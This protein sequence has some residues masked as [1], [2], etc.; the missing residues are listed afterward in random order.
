MNRAD[1]HASESR[2]LKHPLFIWRQQ[3]GSRSAPTVMW[4]QSRAHLGH[5]QDDAKVVL[6]HERLAVLA[7]VPFRL[8]SELFD[9]SLQIE[10]Q[11][12]SSHRTSVWSCVLSLGV[13]GI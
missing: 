10:L 4:R 8:T 5:G 11:K 6:C 12:W 7:G 13:R 1:E 2:C 3:S 9:I